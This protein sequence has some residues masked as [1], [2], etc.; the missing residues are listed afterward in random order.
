LRISTIKPDK[1]ALIDPFDGPE[2]GG[3]V[4]FDKIFIEYNCF[5]ESNSI[6]RLIG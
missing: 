2:F 6:I 1:L 3:D 5:G 4:V